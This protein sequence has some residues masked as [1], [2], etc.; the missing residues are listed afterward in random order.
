MRAEGTGALSI[1]TIALNI[2]EDRKARTIATLAPLLVLS[3]YAERI[4]P[5]LTDIEWPISIGFRS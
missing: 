3:I 5:E 4:F 2:S 1:D